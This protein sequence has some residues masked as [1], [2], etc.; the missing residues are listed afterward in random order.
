MSLHNI[1]VTDVPDADPLSS[2]V[3]FYALINDQ[4]KPIIVVRALHANDKNE[5]STVVPAK[6]DAGVV[7]CVIPR[8]VNPVLLHLT[9]R[10]INKSRKAALTTGIV[11]GTLYEGHSLSL[12]LDTGR[13]VTISKTAPLPIARI[14]NFSFLESSAAEEEEAEA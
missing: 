6:S 7:I 11:G 14:R 9:P 10:V 4:L 2:V 13:Y 3:N 12:K 5:Y 8:G 1:T